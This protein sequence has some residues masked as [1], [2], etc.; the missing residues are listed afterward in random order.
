[1]HLSS[2]G[3]VATILLEVPCLVV[4]HL[5]LLEVI[6]RPLQLRRALILLPSRS[7]PERHD[8]LLSSFWSDALLAK[9]VWINSSNVQSCLKL[10]GLCHLDLA[11]SCLT[12]F[13]SS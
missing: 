5:N 12:C 4:H 13:P 8:P 9:F 11:S 7:S 3:V 6:I 2:E 10:A 1:M